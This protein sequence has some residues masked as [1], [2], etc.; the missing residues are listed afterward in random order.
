MSRQLRAAMHDTASTEATVDPDEA[1]A[2]A[3]A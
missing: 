3:I 1:I 2:S